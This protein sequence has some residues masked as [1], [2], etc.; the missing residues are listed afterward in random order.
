MSYL[1]NASALARELANF[2]G[3]R[4]ASLL[5][6]I[7]WEDGVGVGFKKRVNDIVVREFGAAM[8]KSSDVRSIDTSRAEQAILNAESHLQSI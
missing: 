4:T 7:N 8:S 3:G 2:Q 1:S 5:G 6:G